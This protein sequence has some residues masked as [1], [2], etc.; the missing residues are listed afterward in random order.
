MTMQ[1][2]L[3]FTEGL[4]RFFGATCDLLSL[5]MA[6]NSGI[7]RIFGFFVKGT[8]LFYFFQLFFGPDALG[9]ELV[10]IPCGLS[11]FFS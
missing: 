10:L 1:Q 3:L 8:G 4:N 5:F 11:F 7:F 6:I 9:G 2:L